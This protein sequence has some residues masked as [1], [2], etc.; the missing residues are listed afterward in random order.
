MGAVVDASRAMSQ[1][2]TA[3][4]VDE[5]GYSFASDIISSMKRKGFPVANDA[6]DSGLTAVA[7]LGH[8]AEFLSN[9]G[10][11]TV[12]GVMEVRGADLV[13]QFARLNMLSI[14]NS[15]I[16][17]VVGEIGDFIEDKH[18]SP[19]GGGTAYKVY[20]VTDVVIDGKGNLATNT[21]LDTKNIFIPVTTLAKEDF[22]V[23]ETG[24]LTYTFDVKKDS[25][26]GTENYPLRRGHTEVVIVGTDVYFSDITNED[27]TS[28]FNKEKTYNTKK[29]TFDVKYTDGQVIVTLAD[30]DTLPVGTILAFK[31]S[32]SSAATSETRTY[33]GSDIKSK[34][35]VSELVN[36]GAKI[37]LIDDAEIKKN[38]GLALLPRG[39]R[40][41]LEKRISE[42]LGRIVKYISVL[43]S[44]GG[45][46]DVTQEDYSTKAEEFKAVLNLI[47]LASKD[48]AETTSIAGAG[49]VSIFGGK[50]LV[51]LMNLASSS[52]GGTSL[53]QATEANGFQ[54]LGLLNNTYP[55]YYH[56]MYE[57]DNPMTTKDG[58]VHAT[59]EKNDYYNITICG[60]AKES[61][62]RIVLKG[63][64]VP[65]QPVTKVGVDGN[66]VM[67]IPVTGQ[68]ILSINKNS[69]SQKL[70]RKIYIKD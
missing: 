48:I 50:R 32:M 8:N 46:V 6:I 17:D 14:I 68:Q 9:V 37:N 47:S 53:V 41:G 31:A 28:D 4:G 42:I 16:P 1:A 30:A 18:S 54:Y 34:T 22:Q 43:A 23:V 26:Q 38:I 67:D 62:R 58:I 63:M 29:I 7:G 25:K 70:S 55:C 10:A 45:S 66:L 69:K 44:N 15:N 39:I 3:D 49:R 35:Y 13:L 64:P 40:I 20:E 11:T 2:T 24:K 61:S 12:D 33:F 59:A 57:D 56:P 27:S 5:D 21:E 51:S 19:V 60:M 36:F 52:N 65:I